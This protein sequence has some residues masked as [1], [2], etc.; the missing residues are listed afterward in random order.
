MANP[1][2]NGQLM[3]DDNGYPVMGGTSSADNETIVNSSFNPITRRLLVDS[4][5]G[6]GGTGTWYTV[7]GTIDGVNDT[8]TIATAVTSDF[9]L[10]L[11]RQLQIQ[12]IGMD[13]WDYSYSAGVG[14]TTITYNTPPDASLSGQPHVA[15]VVS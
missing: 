11:A 10:S 12:D 13:T 8:F 1:T 4:S 9:V 6:G 3:K 14:S 5:G 7:S 2:Q 15:F